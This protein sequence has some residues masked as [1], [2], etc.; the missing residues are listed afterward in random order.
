MVE[1]ELFAIRI[2]GRFLEVVF[3]DQLHCPTRRRLGIQTL[4]TPDEGLISTLEKTPKFGVF[5]TS[6]SCVPRRRFPLCRPRA[7]K[8]PR[9]LRAGRRGRRERSPQWQNRLALP[10]QSAP[11]CAWLSQGPA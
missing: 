10:G 7:A 3:F 1:Q 9:E 2:V 6:A 4:P 8:D 11:R 5:P